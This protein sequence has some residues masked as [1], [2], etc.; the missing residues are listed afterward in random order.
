MRDRCLLVPRVE[1]IGLHAHRDIE[2]ETDLHA[3]RLR[4]FLRSRQLPLRIPLHEL[5]EFDFGPV[6]TLSKLSAFGVV[7][8]PPLLRPFPP[9][10]PEFMPQHL[11]TG[12]PR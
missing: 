11:K 6:R 1:P 5:D 7:G 12:E 3:E 8:L 9:W 2:V 4:T 10:L